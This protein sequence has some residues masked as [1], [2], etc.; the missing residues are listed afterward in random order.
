MGEVLQLSAPAAD[1]AT[2]AVLGTVRVDLDALAALDSVKQEMAGAAA[3]AAAKTAPAAP[4]TAAPATAAPAT[5]A[6]DG[7]ARP[8][9]V[10]R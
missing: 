8:A 1:G 7:P 9:A 5:A 2:E 10:G 3:P 4:A 6:P